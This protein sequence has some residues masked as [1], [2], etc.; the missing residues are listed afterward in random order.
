[1][2]F[3]YLKPTL[4]LGNVSTSRSVRSP[5]FLFLPCVFV[6]VL[7]ARGEYHILSALNLL[8]AVLLKFNIIYVV[9]LVLRNMLVAV[10]CN[11][12]W[13][14]PEILSFK[15]LIGESNE[16]S[17][18]CVDHTSPVKTKAEFTLLVSLM[19]ERS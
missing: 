2:S 16:P 9:L 15:E 19:T 17:K 8:S 18:S 3:A 14:I 5:K 10:N 12:V 6:F 7:N 11:F 1:M 13:D 4:C